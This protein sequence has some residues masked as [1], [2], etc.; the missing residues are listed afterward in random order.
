MSAKPPRAQRFTRAFRLR[1]AREFQLV[2]ATRHRRESGPLLLYGMPNDLG[3]PRIGFSVSRKVGGAVTRN[4]IKRRLRD[5][6]R[7]LKVELDES[8][9]YVVVVR[10]HKPTTQINYDRHL[11]TAMGKVVGSWSGKT[12]QP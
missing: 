4:R 1:H 7:R 8:F 10:P 9:D 3:N 11:R 12:R 2:Y 6:F 5:S